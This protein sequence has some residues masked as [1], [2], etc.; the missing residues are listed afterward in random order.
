MDANIEEIWCG[1]QH[2]VASQAP[3]QWRASP[4]MLVL[5][6]TPLGSLGSLVLPV[7]QTDSP[8]VEKDLSS[9]RSFSFYSKVT[10][11]VKSGAKSEINTSFRSCLFT[12]QQ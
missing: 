1:E 3:W 5:T 9:P 8:C 4:E 12:A 11:V 10:E 7:E 2:Q 6:R